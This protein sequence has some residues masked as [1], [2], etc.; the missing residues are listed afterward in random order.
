MIQQISNLAKAVPLDSDLKGGEEGA[1]PAQLQPEV[2]NEF[3][4]NYNEPQR[5]DTLHVASLVQVFA[6]RDHT[7]LEHLA[8]QTRTVSILKLET[9]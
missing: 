5:D 4:S 3:I 7:G 1:F 9:L 6:C 2:E 8:L